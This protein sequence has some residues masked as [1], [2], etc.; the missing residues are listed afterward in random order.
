VAFSHTFVIPSHNQGQFLAATIE[1]L[2]AQDDPCSQILISEDY[3]SDNSLE[4]AQAYVARFPDKI[5]LTRPPDHK[6]MFPN[7]NWAIGQVTTEWISVMGS[8]DQALPNFVTTI[9]QGVAKTPDVV[10]VGAN[11][12][13]I[14]GNDNLLFTE[15]VLS[16]PEVMHPP[17]TF[18]LQLPANRVHPAAH[19]F[20]RSAWEKV[21]GFPYDVKLYGDW[22][23]W[24]SL[25]P[26]GDFVHMRRTIARYRINYRPGL[27]IAR[28]NQTLQDEITVRLDLIPRIAR[29]FDNVSH[30]RL[31]LASRRRFRHMLNRISLDLNGSDPSEQVKLFEP[32][33]HELGPHAL[34]LLDR[35]ARS[36]P[37]GLGWFDSNVV[38]PVREIYKVL[39]PAAAPP[40]RA[41]GEAEPTKPSIVV[42]IGVND[43]GW[44]ETLES[45]LAQSPPQDVVAVAAGGDKLKR[46]VEGVAGDR[47]RVIAAPANAEEPAAAGIEAANG[48]WIVVARPGARLEGDVGASIAQACERAPDA[49]ALIEGVG[50]ASWPANLMR[51]LANLVRPPSLFAFRKSAWRAAGGYQPEMLALGDQALLLKLCQHG[52]CAGGLSIGRAP[53]SAVDHW[54]RLHDTEFLHRTLVPALVSRRGGVTRPELDRGSR[55]AFRAL[56][57]EA[58]ALDKDDRA[59]TADLLADWADY[60]GESDLLSDMRAGRSVPTT[61]P[62]SSVKRSLRTFYRALR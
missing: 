8:D 18:Y 27:E 25:T 6:G 60:L 29:Q 26:L 53:A 4:I 24:L 19:A 17:Q 7:W 61:R 47:A 59:R 2:L 28:M 50:A 39:Q 38:L 20:R 56:V 45:A 5:R 52:V 49:V 42:P 57:K 55:I 32:W 13:F 46:E 14:D 35:F 31:N 30:W 40:N 62:V 44:R 43:S 41:S 21:G 22:A 3:S 23:F 12:D 1:S 11:W 16:L 51:G 36:E 58:A 37:I 10:V 15:K 34:R 9:R 33:A 54:D 48:N